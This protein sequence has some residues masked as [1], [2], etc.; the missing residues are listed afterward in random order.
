MHSRAVLVL[1]LLL[2][3]CLSVG[4]SLAQR[5]VTVKRITAQ[6][7][8]SDSSRLQDYARSAG[9]SHSNWALSGYPLE[10]GPESEWGCEPGLGSALQS[11]CQ[12]HGFRFV[13]IALPHPH[14]YS[15]LAFFAQK[16]LLK[17]AGLEP[18]GTLIE[19]FS[20]FDATT[21]QKTGLLPLW[22]VF[23]TRDSLEF[24][25]SM[26]SYFKK[27]QPIFFSPLI[28]FSLTPDLVP[29][30]GW[31]AAL[32]GLDWRN[33]GA[34]PSHYP[35]DAL[36]LVHWSDPLRLWA[37]GHPRPVNARLTPEQLHAIA[38]SLPS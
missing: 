3:L 17:E 18:S 8:L 4:S 32:Q 10:A 5:K 38:A 27:H 7:F 29:W 28:T 26:R 12:R 23:N 22:L 1:S 13:E 24:L 34:R 37:A 14:D 33:I 36:A 11:F 30:S 9:L 16:T 2:L 31:Q 6:E 25:Q 35:A 15:R 21:V 19:M 20:Q